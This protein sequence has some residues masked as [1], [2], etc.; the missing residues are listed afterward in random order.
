MLVVSYF[1]LGATLS[2]GFY[3]PRTFREAVPIILVAGMAGL[4]PDIHKRLSK[5]SKFAFQS[6]KLIIPLFVLA[7]ILQRETINVY[8]INKLV[9]FAIGISALTGTAYFSLISPRTRHTN[10]LI[11][12]IGMSISSYFIMP[13]LV[14]GVVIGL[15]SR[16]ILDFLSNRGVALFAPISFKKF[17]LKIINTRG[18][19]VKLIPVICVCLIILK[20]SIQ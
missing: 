13:D 2:L 11:Y 8:H 15:S 14:V 20:Y 7:F 5:L 3:N 19:V 10:W 17:K 9:K 12:M 18:I 4:W 16:I 1:A 6:S